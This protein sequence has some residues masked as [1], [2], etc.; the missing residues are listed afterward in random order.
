MGRWTTS[1]EYNTCGYRLLRQDA[2]LAADWVLL[3]PDLI[4]SQGSFGGTYEMPFAYNAGYD[5]PL[6]RWNSG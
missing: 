1:A 4:P 5:A 6:K 3:T 2:A